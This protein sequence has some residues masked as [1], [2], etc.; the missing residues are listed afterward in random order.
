MKKRLP[1]YQIKMVIKQIFSSF[2]FTYQINTQN[3]FGTIS[4]HELFQV[5]IT[6]SHCTIMPNIFFSKKEVSVSFKMST[7]KMIN[8]VETTV[9][10]MLAGAVAS[11]PGLVKLENHRVVL[12]SGLFAKTFQIFRLFVLSFISRTLH[13]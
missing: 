6:N 5:H 1:I 10:E 12:R 9:D 3:M 8:S 7:K 2:L 4:L 11:N 13:R